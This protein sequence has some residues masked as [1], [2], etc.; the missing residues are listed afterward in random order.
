MP[1][2]LAEALDR[3]ARAKAT[4]E[5]LPRTERCAVLWRLMTARSE[6]MRAARLERLVTGSGAAGP[7]RALVTDKQ[8]PDPAVRDLAVGTPIAADE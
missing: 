2:D 3:N 8:D 4:F 5:G 1:P 7:A 6:T